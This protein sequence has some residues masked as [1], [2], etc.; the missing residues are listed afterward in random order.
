MGTTQN[1][2][3]AKIEVTAIHFISLIFGIILYNLSL[4]LPILQIITLA[5]PEDAA[6]N[7]DHVNQP[8]DSET[9][10]RQKIKNSGSNLSN[11][12]TMYAKYTKEKT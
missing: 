9:S 5:I 1:R 7:C 8:P 10:P 3:T 6:R 4:P 11:I 2:S 12:E